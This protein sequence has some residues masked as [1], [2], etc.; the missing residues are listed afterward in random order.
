MQKLIEAVYEDGVIKPLAKLEVEEGRHVTLLLLEALEES[1]EEGYH[2]LVARRHTW[3]RQLYLKGR[4]LT[5]G[6]LVYNMRADQ[7]LPE[8]AADRYD[9]PIE[10]IQEALAY[11]N[12]HRELVAAE[13]EAEK[14][15][16][17]E[18]GYRLEPEDLPG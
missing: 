2:H 6:Q 11:Y 15:Y 8:Q 9:F 4:N 17:R 18:K 7:L 13:A 14:R 1:S 16:L 5:V 10:A 3:R 12:S